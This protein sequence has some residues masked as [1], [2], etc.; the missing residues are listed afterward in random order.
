MSLHRRQSY[1]RGAGRGVRGDGR[2]GCVWG[3]VRGDKEERSAVLTVPG[4]ENVSCVW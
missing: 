3:G 4:L 1:G 2:G